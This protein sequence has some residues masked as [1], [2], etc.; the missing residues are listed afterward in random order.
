MTPASR[1]EKYNCWP[2]F[3][4]LTSSIFLKFVPLDKISVLLQISARNNYTIRHNIQRSVHSQDYKKIWSDVLKAD[5]P[6]MS[7]I[8][9]RG[10]YLSPGHRRLDRSISNFMRSLIC[11]MK[12]EVNFC[13]VF[14]ILDFWKL[15]W[16]GPFFSAV[17]GGIC[18]SKQKKTAIHSTTKPNFLTCLTKG[19]WCKKNLSK[20]IIKWSNL[21][22]LNPSDLFEEASLLRVLDKRILNVTTIVS[23]IFTGKCF[24]LSLFTPTPLVSQY[25]AYISNVLAQFEFIG[26]ALAF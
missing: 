24:L 9:L 20:N 12:R 1:Q 10:L 18:S 6:I 26:V 25:R 11:T 7:I 21:K 3:Q 16:L 23:F 17:Q 19:E 8:V 13:D 14:G 22:T 2:K 15:S 4:T 5:A